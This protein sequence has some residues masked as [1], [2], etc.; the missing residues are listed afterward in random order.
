L[1]PAV[2]GFCGAAKAAAW[3]YDEFVK[4]RFKF[5]DSV[6]VTLKAKKVL[7]LAKMPGLTITSD[8]QVKLA[9]TVTPTSKHVWPT[10]ENIR[11]FY[12]QTA[13]YQSTPPPIPLVD[14]GIA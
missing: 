9:G 3:P 5:V 11:P 2:A 6:A 10:A 1:G 8:S 4:D 14:Y 7:V 12:R 13:Q